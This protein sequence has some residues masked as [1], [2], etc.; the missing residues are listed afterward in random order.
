MIQNMTQG[1]PLKL[2]LLFTLPVLLGSVFQHLY[3]LTD[4]Y[5][6]GYFLGLHALSVI[7]VSS[8]V[9]VMALYFA[10]GFTQG[11]AILTAQRFGADD[12]KGMRHSFA[13]GLL[14]CLLLCFA[15]TTVSLSVLDIGLHIVQIPDDIFVDVK[16][17]LTVLIYA[18]SAMI[19]YNFFAAI[20]RALG[21]S[22]TPLY[23]LVF[24]AS[25]NLAIN[26]FLICVCHFDVIAGAYGTAGAQFSSVVLCAL[27]IYRRYHILHLKKE[28]CHFHLKS[29]LAHLKIALTMGIQTTVLGVGVIIVQAACN[30]FGSLTIAAFTSASRL[31]QLFCVPIFALG[32]GITNYVAQNYGAKR[33]DRIR[34]GVRQAFMSCCILCAS[35][36]ATMYLFGDKLMMFFLNTDN[37]QVIHEA[38]MFL[39]IVLPCYIFLGM[40]C[41]FRH[42]IQGMGN[43]I[44]PFSAC[45]VELSMRAIAVF[46]LSK[47]Y[48]YTGLCFS[49]PTAWIAGGLWCLVWYFVMINKKKKLFEKNLMQPD[50]KTA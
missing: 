23:F 12:M 49:T 30:S 36:S 25:L 50:L 31:E 44:L 45:M 8:P 35:L 27:Y 32:V 26:L 9:F 5:I 40:I 29:F 46:Y 42:A 47:V 14:L 41:V 3:I 6:A 21:D 15:L 4:I 28:E 48:G 1:N 33:L 17:F 39:Y 13:T 7:G 19:F 20:L 24:S 37:P 11:L 43:S 16:R 2:I 22:R 38:V 34:Q 10:N 18:L